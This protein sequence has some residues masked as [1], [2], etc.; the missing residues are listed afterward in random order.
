[1]LTNTKQYIEET[2]KLKENY[3]DN[4]LKIKETIKEKESQNFFVE[5]EKIETVEELKKKMKRIKKQYRF[6]RRQLKKPAS[7]YI[8]LFICIGLIFGILG[9]EIYFLKNRMNYNND[10]F[11][12]QYNEN[13][14]F[15]NDYTEIA[16]MWLISTG[17]GLYAPSSI[18]I[19]YTQ[20]AKDIDVEYALYAM[21]ERLGGEKSEEQSEIKA[22]SAYDNYT[23]T[24]DNKLTYRILSKSIKKNDKIL[25]IMF[26]NAG[27][28]S[29]Q[30]QAD[31]YQ[32][33]NTITLK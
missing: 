33:Y 32:V 27:D 30:E 20:D 10:Y 2:K 9:S 12:F 17:G 31:L 8:M 19:G 15:I 26:V 23:L 21:Q 25:T 16:N 5:E 6:E 18:L 11:S 13:N 22:F 24:L 28:L 4:I 14:I 3:K 7:F 29:K 1:M